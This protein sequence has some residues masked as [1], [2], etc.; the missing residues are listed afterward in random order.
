MKGDALYLIY[1]IYHDR[2]VVMARKLKA[3]E[4]TEKAEKIRE[5]TGRDY[6]ILEDTSGREEDDKESRAMDNAAK[7]L[8][9][10]KVRGKRQK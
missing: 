2:Y 6:L 1:G 10:I 3:S 7:A 5:K 8:C 4:V 9:S